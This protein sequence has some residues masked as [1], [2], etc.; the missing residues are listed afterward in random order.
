MNLIP[1]SRFLPMQGKALAL[2]RVPIHPRLGENHGHG[3]GF[4][5]A[6][7]GIPPIIVGD[8]LERA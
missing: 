1:A 2:K 7:S 8:S 3:V 6:P 5:L 4:L